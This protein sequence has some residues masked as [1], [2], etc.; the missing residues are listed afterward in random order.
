MI[1]GRTS[2]SLSRGS[3]GH[4]QRSG[5]SIRWRIDY[6][7]ATAGLAEHAER[8]NDHASVTVTFNG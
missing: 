4:S 3:R 2:G 5:Q 6:Q 7:I 1:G 8:W